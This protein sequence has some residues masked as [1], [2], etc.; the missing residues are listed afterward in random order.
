[1]TPATL[2][3]QP[4]AVRST[5]PQSSR[6]AAAVAPVKGQRATI[7]G[8]LAW[9]ERS[10]GQTHSITADWL[11]EAYAESDRG[12]W[13]TRLSGMERDGLIECCGFATSI[14]NGRPRKVKA[15][16]LTDAGR[17]AAAR[18]AHPSAKP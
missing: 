1:M 11:H 4:G 14:R 12:T 5:D 8:T 16:R 2:F 15:Y 10:Y 7:L 13:S 3:D 6:D 9:R 17:D 18:L